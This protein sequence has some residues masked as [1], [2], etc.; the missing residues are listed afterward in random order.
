M[1]NYVI[2]YLPED[3]DHAVFI[4]KEDGEPYFESEIIFKSTQRD[5]CILF[6]QH[7]E[8]LDLLTEI[9][10]ELRTLN[11][12]KLQQ[13]IHIPRGGLITAKSKA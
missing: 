11:N 9:R 12:C 10:D 5:K 7:R 1:S 3:Q 6:V 4:S 13:K 8:T 2:H